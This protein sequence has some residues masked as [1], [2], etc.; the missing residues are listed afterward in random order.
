VS[1]VVKGFS[2]ANSGDSGNFGNLAPPPPVLTQ[3]NPRA[4]KVTQESAEGRTL[5]R[6]SYLLILSLFV[7][8]V[9]D[10]RSA[11]AAKIFTFQ[12]AQLPGFEIIDIPQ[13]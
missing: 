12:A 9:N 6:F 3:F 11:S 13:S 5:F 8:I 4:P 7:R 2:I 10:L 1:F